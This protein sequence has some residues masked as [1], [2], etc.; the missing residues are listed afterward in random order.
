MKKPFVNIA[1]SAA[2]GASM[3][4]TALPAAAQVNLGVKVQPQVGVRVGGPPEPRTE[5]H[6]HYVY[7]GYDSGEWY[8]RGHVYRHHRY[9]ARYDGYDCYEAFQY[10]WEDDHRVRYESTWCYDE[11]DRPYE[12]RSTRVVV[13]ID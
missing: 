2:L 9:D 1:L 13:R 12:A 5:V 7:E 3:A 4:L 8:P 6:H 10:S 11:Y